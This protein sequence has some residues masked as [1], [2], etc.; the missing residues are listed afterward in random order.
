MPAAFKEK[1]ASTWDNA[2]TEH[3]LKAFRTWLK[4]QPHLPHDIP[5]A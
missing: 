4:Q 2:A 3:E 5:G 1:R